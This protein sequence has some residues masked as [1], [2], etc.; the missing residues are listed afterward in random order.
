[1]NNKLTQE[2]KD[3]LYGKVLEK[4]RIRNIKRKKML[5]VFIVFISVVGFTTLGFSLLEKEDYKNFFI[6]ETENIT[7]NDEYEYFDDLGIKLEFINIDKNSLTLGINIKYEN[8]ANYMLNFENISVKNI[9]NE[10]YLLYDD[11]FD[12]EIQSNVKGKNCD[13]KIIS[14]SELIYIVKYNL[15]EMP[16]LNN[17]KISVSN[18]NVEK[19]DVKKFEFEYIKEISIEE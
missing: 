7:F 13:K 11:M 10:E 1:M 6:S 15:L 8:I 19:I 3:D 12:C 2:Y 9:V 17:M 18:L 4:K 5:S 14:N 16:D